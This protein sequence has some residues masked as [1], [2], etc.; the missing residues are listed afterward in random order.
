M[1][2]RILLLITLLFIIKFHPSYGFKQSDETSISSFSKNILL[3]TSD[4]P[5]PHHVEPTLAI[6]ENDVIF[7]G[8][9]NAFSH[10]GP[11]VRVS[12]SRSTNYGKSWSKSFDMPMFEGLNTGQSDP[13][14]VWHNQFLYYAYL[15]YSINT[16]QLSQITVAKS[17][18][19]GDTWTPVTASD[20]NGFADKETMTVSSDGTVY[21][22]YDDLVYNANITSVRLTRS[23]DNGDSFS[24][25]GVIADSTTHPEDHLG[26][27]VITDGHNDVYVAWVWFSNNEWGD[28]YLSASQDQGETFSDEIDINPFSENATFETSP[29]QRASRATLPVVRFD[30]NDRLYVLWADRHIEGGEWDIFIRYSEDYGLNWSDR[31]QVNPKWAGNQW[32]PEMD[33]D[34]KGRCH[35]VW[36]DEHKDTYGPYYR[37]ITF[38]EEEGEENVY[39]SPVA[40]ASANTSSSFTRPGDYFTIKVDSKDIPHVVWSD[41]RD[42]E[43]DIYYS[44]GILETASNSTT[45]STS[46]PASTNFSGILVLIVLIGINTIRKRTV[47]KKL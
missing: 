8:W 2:I 4:T 16:D 15:E 32:Q 36:Y 5:Y 13:W 17:I 33:I 34:S 41:G 44:H 6:G 3:S 9:K 10:N 28:V 31:F 45:I 23:T 22:A 35:I 1:K 18:D 47:K 14:L 40:I 29:D 27:Y 30:Q 24:E 21:V 39:S 7:A 25:V 26:P 46:D 11:G 20:G 12:F 19:F 38:P 42:N 37:T 43:M